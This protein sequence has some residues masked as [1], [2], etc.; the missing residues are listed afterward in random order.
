VLKEY[1]RWFRYIL[2]DEYQDTNTAQY[3]W[4]RLLAQRPGHTNICCVGDDDQSIYGWRGAEWKTSCAS[5][6]IF[7]APSHPARAQLPLHRT[8]PRAAG[9]LIAHNEGRLGKTLFTEQS[10]PEHERV[11]VHAAWDSE[12]EARAIGEEIEQAQIKGRAQRHGDPGPRLVPDARVRGPLR[13]AGAELPRHRR[14]ALLR[15]PGNPR[16][17]GVISACVCQPA[18][19]LAFERIVNTPKRGLGDCP[20]GRTDCS[21]RSARWT[22][23]G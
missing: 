18:D 1:Q 21:R 22:K 12:E 13:H 10:D 15:T 11:M 23:A 8:Y 4:L 3:M 14:P 9:H 19:D 20:A 16:R 2:V 6:R 5:K 17:H 7:P